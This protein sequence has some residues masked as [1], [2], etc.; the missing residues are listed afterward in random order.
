MRQDC[1]LMPDHNLEL[2]MCKLFGELSS[3]HSQ[4]LHF[5]DLNAREQSL[6]SRDYAAM[7]LLTC[8]VNL[9]LHSSPAGINV[10]KSAR[11]SQAPQ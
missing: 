10:L 9:P 3:L 1:P 2:R 11:P 8:K 6:V 4:P 5:T 7:T